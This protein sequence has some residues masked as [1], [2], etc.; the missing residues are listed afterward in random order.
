MKKTLLL[1]MISLV[2]S[3]MLI[4]QPRH[5]GMSKEKR[6]KVESMKVAFITQKLDITPDEAK[7]FWPVYNQMSDELHALREKRR[8]DMKNLKMD[9]DSLTDKEY[10]RVF[11][12]D[13]QFRQSELDILKKYQPQLKKVLPMKKLARLPRVEDEFRQEL[14]EKIQERNGKGGGGQKGKGR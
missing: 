5:G 10:E 9:S 4:A 7:V 13:L 11:D 6:E 14:L 12:S 2:S 3:A 8:Q 1:L